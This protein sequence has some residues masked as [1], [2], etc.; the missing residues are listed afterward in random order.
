MLFHVRGSPLIRFFFLTLSLVVMGAG[1]AWLTSAKKPAP[2]H[3]A[4]PK[5]SPSPPFLSVPY[6]LQLSSEATGIELN[7]GI[8][9]ATGTRG[10]LQLD[11]EN[12]HVSITIHW[13]KPPSVEEQRFAKLILEPAGKP[14]FTHVFDS[15]GDIDDL[16]EL[17]LSHE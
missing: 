8:S 3:A 10:M 4:Q 7:T 6:Q 17:P 12:P 1:L 2:I 16:L 5:V 9:K 14:T 13:K 11:A 15:L